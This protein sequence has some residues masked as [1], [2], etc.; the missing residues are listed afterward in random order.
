MMKTSL[1]NCFYPRPITIIIT[2]PIH[3]SSRCNWLSLIKTNCCKFTSTS[4]FSSEFPHFHQ[5]T[6]TMCE[7]PTRSRQ[8]NCN[9]QVCL[10]TK[11]IFVVFLT[12]LYPPHR[13]IN[14]WAVLQ[15]LYVSIDGNSKSI[16]IF[17][18]TLLFLYILS[19]ESM[20]DLSRIGFGS[21]ILI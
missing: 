11:V 7:V 14:N 2:K 10:S 5:Q 12:K 15:K 16:F 21:I 17:D 1:N 6:Q 20:Y 19:R 13:C 9:E 4:S 8:C 18:A 3:K